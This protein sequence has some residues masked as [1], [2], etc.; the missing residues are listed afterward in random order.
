MGSTTVTKTICQSKEKVWKA[1]SEH[2]Q[3]HHWFFE[4]IPDFKAEIGFKTW[5]VVKNEDSSFYHLWEV[6]EVIKNKTLKVE[7][8]YPDYIKEP[9]LVTFKLEDLESNKTRL[10]V[11]ADGIEKF[12]NLNIP[13]FTRESCIGGWEYF[14][15]QLK[16]YLEK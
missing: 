6:T 14:T 9:F 2:S 5:F 16:E 15:T 1:I 13:E 11:I 8:T 4:N 7:W 3:L 12:S 10:T